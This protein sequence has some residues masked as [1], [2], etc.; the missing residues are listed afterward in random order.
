MENVMNVRTIACK[1]ALVVL[2]TLVSL[3]VTAQGYPSKPV[4]IIVPA[5]PGGVTDILAR[6]VG[7]RL[8][9]VWGQAVIIENRPGAGQIIGAEA[10]ARSPGGGPAAR[11]GAVPW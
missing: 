11:R 7:Q 8:S 5:A 4:K 3:G 9:D 1:A 2:L 6:T 10:V